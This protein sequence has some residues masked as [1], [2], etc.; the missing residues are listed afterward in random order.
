VE[1]ILDTVPHKALMTKLQQLNVSPFILRWICTYLTARQQK[2]VLG[3]LVPRS[4]TPPVFD[5]L[6]YAKM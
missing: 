1:R 5:R 3:S 2:V 6:Q 4:S